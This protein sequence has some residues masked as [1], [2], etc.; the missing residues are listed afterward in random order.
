MMFHPGTTVLQVKNEPVQEGE[1]RDRNS[2]SAPF[3][4]FLG[5]IAGYRVNPERD[6]E[7]T[8]T[9]PLLYP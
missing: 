3:I 4:R 6:L 9:T 2:S 8:L 1:N 5:T 7:G